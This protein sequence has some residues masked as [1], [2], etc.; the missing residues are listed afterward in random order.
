MRNAVYH[1]SDDGLLTIQVDLKQ[2]LGESS[3]GKSYLVGRS[4]GQFEELEGAEDYAIAL[5]VIKYKERK[6]SK[7][8]PKV[9]AVT[10]LPWKTSAKPVQA[11]QPKI[12]ASAIPP[13]RSARR[14]L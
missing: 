11:S 6:K 5:T 10:P 4:I 14:S 9:E 8:A 1:V 2:S 7:A 12:D 3:T 13:G